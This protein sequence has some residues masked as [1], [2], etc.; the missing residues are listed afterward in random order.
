MAKK[1]NK[2]IIDLLNVDRAYELAAI[3]QYLGH[4]YEVAG[5]ESPSLQDIFKET[6]ID[7][8]KH[9]EELAERIVFLGG[10][11]TQKPT[12]AGREDSVPR[13]HTHP[14]ANGN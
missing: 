3:I 11:P 7:E 6:S 4:H 9:A 8:M 1:G 12:R 10:I 14:E 5:M 13:R 2:K